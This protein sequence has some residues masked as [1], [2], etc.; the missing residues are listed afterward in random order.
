MTGAKDDGRP[1][2][3]YRD[4]GVVWSGNTSDIGER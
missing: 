4:S 3:A 2:A 1:Y